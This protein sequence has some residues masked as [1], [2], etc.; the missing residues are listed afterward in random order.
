MDAA[1]RFTGGVEAR[2]HLA[3]DVK[4]LCVGVDLQAAH[5]VVHARNASVDPVRSR[6]EVDEAAAVVEVQVLARPGEFVDAR[7]RGLEVVDRDLEEVGDALDGVGLVQD[8]RLGEDLDLVLMVRDGVRALLDLAVED[9]VAVLARLLEN[10]LAHHVWSSS[11]K[12]L[13]S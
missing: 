2:N 11:T 5:R 12:R 8:A 7:N 10:G 9:R 13:P 4:H 1:R 6:A 3:V